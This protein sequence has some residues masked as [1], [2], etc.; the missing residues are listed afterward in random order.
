MFV[1]LCNGYEL[2]TQLCT[3]MIM[4]SVQLASYK[5]IF[6]V[7]RNT[8]TTHAIPSTTALLGIIRKMTFFKRSWYVNRSRSLH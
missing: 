2:S 6:F 7:F 4:Y 3:K 5:C 1:L 8:K